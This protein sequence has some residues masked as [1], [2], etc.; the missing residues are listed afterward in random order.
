MPG[1]WRDHGNPPPGFVIAD[2]GPGQRFLVETD[3][4]TSARLAKVRQKNTKPELIVRRL[5]HHLGHRFRIQARDL[6]SSPDIVN[7]KRKWAI[8]VHGCYW[9]RHPGCP[10]TTTPKRNREFWLAKFEANQARDS[11]AQSDLEALG[12]RVLVIWQCETKDLERLEARLR[13]SSGFFGDR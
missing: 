9:H 3:E 6:P 10:K 12:Y 13:H 8:F 5:L 1:R 2:A 7:R 4:E 11:R